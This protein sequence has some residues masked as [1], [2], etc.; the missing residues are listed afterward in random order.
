MHSRSKRIYT[1]TFES[2]ESMSSI[3]EIM[4]HALADGFALLLPAAPWIA[5]GAFLL[6]VVWLVLSITER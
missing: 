4:A 6:F 5:A 2:G 1:K 3:A